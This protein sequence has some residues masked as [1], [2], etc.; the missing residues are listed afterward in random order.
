M[1]DAITL[2]LL[3]L[4]QAATYGRAVWGALPVCRT[5]GI[6]AHS[7][8]RYERSLILDGK[9]VRGNAV[10]ALRDVTNQVRA[11]AALWP[12][13]AHSWF[14]DSQP[15]GSFFSIGP[16]QTPLV[17]AT[18]FHVGASLAQA[19][20]A[21]RIAVERRN[22]IAVTRALGRVMRGERIVVAA[23]G[24]EESHDVALR[25]ARSIDARIALPGDAP[26]FN[27]LARTRGAAAV[28]AA[29]QAARPPWVETYA[30]EAPKKRDAKK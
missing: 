12:N 6:Q 13:A 1:P 2:E 24:D 26:D 28:R 7:A 4:R 23:D 8:Q 25:A 19:G 3:E 15:L 16:T 5:F 27:V 21:V 14:P 9:Q 29:I 10:I 22:L 30:G 18:A 17:V 20:F 11:V